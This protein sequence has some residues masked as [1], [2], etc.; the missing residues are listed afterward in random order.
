ML[1]KPLPLCLGRSRGKRKCPDLVATVDPIALY[2]LVTST[3]IAFRIITILQKF[4]I[5]EIQ[6][7]EIQWYKFN[8][9]FIIVLRDN[10]F[11]A[12]LCV[13]ESRIEIRIG[14][15]AAYI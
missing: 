14:N 8:L 11:T 3:C 15:K 10:T 7:E 12:P 9:F 6:F 5:W 2:V 13:V 4:N 1:N